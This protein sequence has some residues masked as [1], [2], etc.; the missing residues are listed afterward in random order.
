M[1]K[2]V[3]AAD[4]KSAALKSVSVRVRPLAPNSRD[5]FLAVFFIARISYFS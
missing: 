2:S 3:D 1:A 5:R 4:S